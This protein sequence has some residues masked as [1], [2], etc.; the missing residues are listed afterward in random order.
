MPRAA[1]QTL[2]A[3]RAAEPRPDR[4]QAILLA[5][6]KLFA[7]RGYHAVSIRQIAEEA[8]VPLALVSYYFGAK[9]ELFIAIF[10]H[11]N[12]TIEA[13]LAALRRV[14]LVPQDEATLGA[15][16]EAFVNPVLALRA[17]AEGEYYALL[18]ARQLYQAV[19]EAEAVLRT[20]FDPMAHAFIDALHAALPWATRAQVAWC[21]Q[22]MLGALLNHLSDTRVV[23]LSRG[24]NRPADPAAAPLLLRF[25]TG[26][27]RAALPAPSPAVPPTRPSRRRPAP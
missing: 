12:A 10:A 20:Y 2:P 4:R 14:P 27:I 1:L 21:Y 3:L 23:G 22:F 13:R 5:A 15:I 6:E 8:Q 18:V 19:D 11:W 24:A 26:G 7:L 17:S 25:I 16:V 9:H